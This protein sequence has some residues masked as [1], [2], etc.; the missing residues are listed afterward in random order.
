MR[1]N[2]ENFF[3]SFGDKKGAF[4]IFFGAGFRIIQADERKEYYKVLSSDEDCGPNASCLNSEDEYLV[5]REPDPI[6]QFELWV[7][8]M[9]RL[10]L[11]N[12]ILVSYDRRCDTGLFWNRPLG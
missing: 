6:D 5:L 11:I 4:A 7:S 8:W 3:R 10:G 9:E 12:D 1:L 2:N